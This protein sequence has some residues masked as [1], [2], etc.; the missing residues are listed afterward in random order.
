MYLPISF[1]I[2]F[3]AP[4]IASQNGPIYSKCST[5]LYNSSSAYEYNLRLLLANITASAPEAHSLYSTMYS[6]GIFGFA[7][8]RPDASELTCANC[9][10]DSSSKLAAAG[11]SST[12]GCG[13][14]ISAVLYQDLCLLSYNNNSYPFFFLERVVGSSAS[15]VTSSNPD[16]FGRRVVELMGRIAFEASMSTDKFGVG[17]AEAGDAQKQK[18]YGMGWCIWNLPIDNCFLCLVSGVSKLPIRMEG[19][20]YYQESCLLRFEVYMFFDQHFIKN[21]TSPELHAAGGDVENGSGDTGGQEN[22]KIDMLLI[23]VIL[24]GVALMF[25]SFVIIILLLRKA[26]LSIVSIKLG[27]NDKE[28]GR[29]KALLLNFGVINAATSNFSEVYKLGEGGFGPVYKGILK[30]GREI[31]VKRLSRTSGQG[32]VELENEVA[33][34]AKL[35]HR[36]LVS[37]L[38]CCMEKEEKLL[39]YEFLP[40]TSLDKHL[41]DPVCKMQLDWGTRYKIIEGI[42]QGL[43]YLHEDSRVRVVHCDL[44]ASNIL[45]DSNMNPKISDF[46]LAKLFGTHEA[47]RNTSRIAGTFGYMA[48]EYALRGY[49]SNK[50][51]VYSY[52][53]LVL[54][55]VTGQRNICLDESVDSVN[56]LS[57]VWKNWKEG[58]AL[59]AADQSLGDRYKPEQVLRCLQIG[60]LCIQED[61]AQ[62]PSIASVVVML[63]SYSFMLPEPLIPAFL[64]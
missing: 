16:D 55:I 12:D 27:A 14:S 13:Q 26:K 30:D 61:P 42:A 6:F 62:R 21:T 37:L 29:G 5:K 31:A 50:S 43:L 56:L 45:L 18:I 10:L 52:G 47:Q 51:D 1:I 60:L 53:V 41:F 64:G 59:N 58:Q 7:Q 3:L 24:E 20:R 35:Q 2:L 54:E 46:G 33:F 17:V 19:G 34:L 23:V 38:G 8:C 36:N 40:N 9:L 28:M 25:S 49:F 22:G 48:P 32:V 11:G 57:S 15:A 63:S 4:R 39:V 44:K